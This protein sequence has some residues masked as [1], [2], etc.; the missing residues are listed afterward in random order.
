MVGDH[1][2]GAEPS[3]VRAYGSARA[4]ECVERCGVLREAGARH[5]VLRKIHACSTRGGHGGKVLRAARACG[6]RGGLRSALFRCCKRCTW[7]CVVQGAGV[8]VGSRV[9]GRGQGRQG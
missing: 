7:P 1:V 5:A 9:E 8:E 4:A 6:T 2:E 3:R